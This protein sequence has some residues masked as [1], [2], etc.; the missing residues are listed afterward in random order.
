MAQNVLIP[1]IL[2][3]SLDQNVSIRFVDIGNIR[4]FWHKKLDMKTCYSPK[5]LW[6]LAISLV[7]FFEL[8]VF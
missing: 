1:S 7:W 5:S 8:N 6:T 2:L 4:T 3:I